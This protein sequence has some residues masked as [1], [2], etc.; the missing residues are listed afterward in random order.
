LYGSGAVSDRQ[1]E[2]KH[3]SGSW[4]IWRSRE[5]ER[6]RFIWAERW[7][8]PAY[9][10]IIL[11]CV[12]LLGWSGFDESIKWI[13]AALWFGLFPFYMLFEGRELTGQME[14]RGSID[15]PQARAQIRTGQLPYFGAV[16]AIVVWLVAL[17]YF[18]DDPSGSPIRYGIVEWVILGH[19][20]LAILLSNRIFYGL[21]MELLKSAPRG[22]RTERRLG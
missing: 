7:N 19:T 2:D 18:K 21:I 17:V 3:M 9:A 22:E 6:P 20:W 1:L 10:L 13:I 5:D 12:P 11:V 8:A 4:K 14:G 16:L 15:A